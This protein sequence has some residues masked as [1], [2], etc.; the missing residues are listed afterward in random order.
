MNYNDNSYYY[1]ISFPI[2]KLNI[3]DFIIIY[4]I[5]YNLLHLLY[6]WVGFKKWGTSQVVQW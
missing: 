4:Y 6:Y 3:H 1:M 5:Y 2:W